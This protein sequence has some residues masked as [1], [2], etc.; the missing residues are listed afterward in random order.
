MTHSLFLALL[1]FI[2]SFSSFSLLFLPPFSDSAACPRKRINSALLTKLSSIMMWSESH[3]GLLG[4]KS[5]VFMTIGSKKKQQKL[6]AKKKIWR[7]QGMFI[8]F[9]YLLEDKLP[10][11]VPKKKAPQLNDFA[12]PTSKAFNLV[13]CIHSS[14]RKQELRIGEVK[15]CCCRYTG[16]SKNRGTPKWMVC[17]GKPY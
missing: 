11:N 6:S 12:V 5:A 14:G 8:H 4:P 10:R 3:F 16:V 2:F 17:T 1:L 15:R 7:N 13:H 9:V